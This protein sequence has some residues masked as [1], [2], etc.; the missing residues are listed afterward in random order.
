MREGGW[1]LVTN[2]DGVDSPALVPLLRALSC[3]GKVRAV[4][5]VQECS[6]TGKIMSRFRKLKVDQVRREGF[7]VWTVDGYPADCANLGMHSLF[8]EPPDLLVSGIN[9]GSNA[10]L[11][12]FLSSGTVGAA[13]EGVLGGVPSVAFSVQLEEGDYAR[14]RQAREVSPAVALLLDRAALV[15]R[16]IVEEVLC[17]GMPGK[18]SMLNVNMPSTT[19]LETPRRLAGMTPTGYGPYFA[20]EGEGRFGYHFSGL[21]VHGTDARGDL[22]VLERGEVAITPVR[23]SLDVELGADDR[24]RFE[25]EGKRHRNGMDRE[26]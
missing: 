19:T 6:W 8:E 20:S 2:D 5:P 26:G 25:R 3:A 15:A 14:W 10:G 22:A 1:I 11:A 16:E 4:V 21:K 9:M 13:V 12:F 23:F 17:N 7:G 24:R 18:V